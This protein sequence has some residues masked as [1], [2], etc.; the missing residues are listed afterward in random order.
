MARYVRRSRRYRKY[1][2]FYRRF[3]RAYGKYTRKYI[4]GTSR[5]TVRAKI[6]LQLTSTFNC[7]P[8]TPVG[9]IDPLAPGVPGGLTLL[10]SELFRNYAALYDEMKIIGA[11]ISMAV[12]TPVGTVTHPAIEFHT[13]WD[14]HRHYQEVL[15]PA[16]EIVA[17]SSHM[18]TI[19]INNN[20]AK[21]SRSLFASDLF[22]NACWMQS[23]FTYNDDA[24]EY[25]HTQYVH[26][27]ANFNAFNP[28]LTFYMT[29]LNTDI[30]TTC[31]IAFS[32]VF[33]VAFRSPRYGGG[34]DVRSAQM[35]LAPLPSESN[36]DGDVDQPSMASE[37]VDDA[38]I[39]DLLE[40][41]QSKGGTV[42]SA[43]ESRSAARSREHL[44]SL[45]TAPVVVRPP[46]KN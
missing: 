45:R 5:S 41:S 46:P 9:V 22:E 28:A 8:S 17:R 20:V 11:R 2:R 16:S 6:G 1:R 3:G 21:I 38:P 33:Y 39:D 29:V 18:Q 10:S 30:D 25:R 26:A 34:G 36:G 37:S 27:G 7:T 35:R 12:V 44:K 15:P 32:A 23:H 40:E 4:N 43:S 13:A 24:H 14:R 31:T 42:T 19:A